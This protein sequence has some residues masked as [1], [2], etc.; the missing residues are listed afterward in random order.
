MSLAVHLVRASGRGC[1]WKRPASPRLPRESGH[2]R[3]GIRLEVVCGCVGDRSRTS[4]LQNRHVARVCGWP[5][6]CIFTTGPFQF[7]I[8]SGRKDDLHEISL[9]LRLRFSRRSLSCNGPASAGVRAVRTRGLCLGASTRPWSRER[10]S[11]AWE[12][13]RANQKEGRKRKGEASSRPWQGA[14]ESVARSPSPGFDAWLTGRRGRGNAS[15]ANFHMLVR[16][17]HRFGAYFA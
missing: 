10:D 2:R 3:F 12:G 4:R 15:R 9:R 7:S 13:L 11:H 16:K 1:V 5:V 8:P 14:Q 17:A 6:T